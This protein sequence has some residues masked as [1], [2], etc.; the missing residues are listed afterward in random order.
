MPPVP[1]RTHSPLPG[2]APDRPARSRRTPRKPR[3]LSR[4]RS[5]GIGL[6]VMLGVTF[7]PAGTWTA[8]GAR[9]P[10]ERIERFAD[11][12]GF[13]WRSHGV[14]FAVGCTPLLEHCPPASFET[15]ARIIHISPLILGDDVQLRSLVL[16]EVGH[17]WQFAVRGWP[18]A[19]D[20]VAAWGHR[21][22]DGLERA[23]D[24]LATSWGAE[25]TEYWTCPPDAVQHMRALYE[26]SDERS[27]EQSDEPTPGH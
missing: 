16:H 7:L 3:S 4:S 8:T 20:D 19:E 17:A 5:V 6:T 2:D 18:Q 12:I 27:D 1:M 14:T 9:D 22:I 10:L 24:C 26:Q 23:A 15:S 13:D 21:G 11:E 25:R